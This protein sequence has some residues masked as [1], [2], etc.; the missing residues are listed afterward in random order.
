MQKT[1]FN[2]IYKTLSQKI[3]NYALWLTRNR[4]ASVEIVQSVFIKL[5]KSRILH[6]EDSEIEAWLITVTRTTSMDFY[7]KTARFSKLRL[8]YFKEA[9]LKCDESEDNREIWMLLDDLSEKE[10]S[11]L[12]LR[13]RMGHSFGEIATTLE[14]TESAVRVASMRALEK[15]R[16]KHGKD[17][18]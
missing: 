13:F 5:W 12:Y 2:Q 9:P 8:K 3:F 6:S 17:L 18:L 4:D 14:M 7:R 16:E 15:L 10:R 11:I 1:R